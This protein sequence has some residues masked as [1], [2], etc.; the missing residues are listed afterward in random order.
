VH[1]GYLD[2]GKR[3]SRALLEGLRVFLN[4][5]PA[6]RA[7]TK[8]SFLGPKFVETARLAAELGLGAVVTCTGRVPYEESLLQM[9]AAS[10]CVLVEADMRE[11]IYLPSKFA[12]Y[13]A[14]RRPVLALSPAVGTIA[15]MLPDVGVTRVDPGDFAGA[16]DALTSLY[17]DWKRGTLESRRISPE[18]A[19]QFAPATVAGEFLDLLA[20]TGIGTGKGAIAIG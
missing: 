14:S 10:V 7:E 15:D 3:S 9:S 19:Q 11:G 16:A 20:R 8:L 6:S 18:L 1:A 13:A 4:A 5:R 17:D 2:L 12:D